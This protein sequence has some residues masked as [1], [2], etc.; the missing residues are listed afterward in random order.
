MP[1]ARIAFGF[2]FVTSFPA[3]GMAI[4][5]AMPVAYFVMN[6]WLENFAYRTTIGVGTF[7]LAASFALAISWLTISFQS[8][9]A[10]LANPVE[11]LRYE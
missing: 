6:R 2:I 9:K 8:I 5:V 4:I 11:A 3:I 7:T 10:A 1:K